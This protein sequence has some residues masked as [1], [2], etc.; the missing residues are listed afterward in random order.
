LGDFLVEDGDIDDPEDVFFFTLS[1]LTSQLPADARMVVAERRR[2]WTRYQEVDLPGVWVGPAMPAE[3]TYDSDAETIDGVAASP[4]VIE[5]TVRVVLDV[6]SAQLEPGEI[7]VAKD[8]DPAW[9]SLMFLSGGLIAD[10]GGV[11][12]HTAV[13]ARELGLPCVVATSNATRVLHSGDVVR[14]DG[15]RGRIE[16]LSRA[17]RQLPAEQSGVSA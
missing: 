13:V 1:E 6:A 16:I 11:M 12:S 10:I 4:G 3:H 15:T 8:T 17:G 2:L 9:A 5:G 14:L 7:L